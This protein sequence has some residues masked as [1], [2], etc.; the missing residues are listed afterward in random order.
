MAIR[1]LITPQFI[2]DTYVLGVN[3]TLDDGSPYPDVL[4]E[5]AIDA[6]INTLELELGITFDPFTVKGERHDARIEH[7]NAFYPFR[8][9]HRPVRSVDALKITIGNAP[10][11]VM[12]TGWAVNTMGQHGQINLIPAGE[13]LGSF[14]FRSGIPLLFGDVFSPYSYV[15]GYFSI[16]YTSGFT[17]IE[18]TA[19][20]P[21]GDVSVEVPITAPLE[22]VKPTISLTVTDAQGGSTPRVRRSGTDSFTISVGTAPNT[23]DM[24][25]S[26]SLHTVDPALIRAIGLMAA[27]APLDIAGDLIA[28]AGVGQF[29]VGVDGLTQS[30]ATTA[31]ATSAGYGARIISYQKQLKDVMGSLRAKYRMMNMFSV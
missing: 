18:G 31:S 11:V 5:N 24:L 29:S 20:I 14:F 2:K 1:D 16:D 8:L 7:K 4:F 3:L 10:E 13:T 9:D 15:P 26:Y 30:I 6:A 25:I 17:F 22:G 21:Q 27:I 12:P 28:G 23:G 19:V